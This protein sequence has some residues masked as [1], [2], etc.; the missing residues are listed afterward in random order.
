MVRFHSKAAMEY[1][2]RKKKSHHHG[3]SCPK[4][5][6]NTLPPAAPIGA[7]DPNKPIDKLRIRPGGNLIVNRAIAFGR[8]KPPP[9]PL[10]ARITL[11][12]TTLRM[13]PEIK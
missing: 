12:V 1:A 11:S 2:Y 9:M 13:K 4:K 8:I 10:M 3:V 7:I 5:P 6:G